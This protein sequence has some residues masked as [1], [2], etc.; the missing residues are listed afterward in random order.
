MAADVHLG[1]LHQKQGMKVTC[2]DRL[3]CAISLPRI[4]DVGKH[5]Y[6]GSVIV[7][8]MEQRKLSNK[9]GFHSWLL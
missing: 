6:P 1:L 9:Q 5:H 3:E 8:M 2:R 7:T 4:A